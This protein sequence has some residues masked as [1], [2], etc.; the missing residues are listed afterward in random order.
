MKAKAKEQVLSVF[1]KELENNS[2]TSGKLRISR[3]PPFTIDAEGFRSD[4]SVVPFLSIDKKIRIQLEP[5]SSEVRDAIRDNSAKLKIRAVDLLGPMMDL[6]SQFLHAAPSNR[7]GLLHEVN[8]Q[9]FKRI[10]AME[11]TVKH[12]DGALILKSRFVS[13]I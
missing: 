1:T 3:D 8:E 13:K 10:E 7:P 2:C 4:G 9:Y 5:V 12:D 11:F 6:L